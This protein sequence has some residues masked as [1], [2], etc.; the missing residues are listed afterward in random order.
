M[1][2]LVA[3]IAFNE[4]KN[5][6]A[7]LADLSANRREYDVVLVD[8]GSDDSTAA[9]GRAAGIPVL[10][11]CI[12][13]G[14]PAGTVTSY[15]AYAYQ[16]GYDVLCQFDG[17][18]QHIAAELPKIIDPVRRGEADYVIGSRFLEGEGFQSTFARRLGI[19]L[20][21]ALDSLIIGQR[22]S[23]VTSGFRAYGRRVI[24]FFACV[25]RFELHDTNQLLLFSHFSGARI[26]EVPARMR[27]RLH[28]ESEFDLVAS[29]TYP[30]MGAVNILGVLLQRQRIQ[31]RRQ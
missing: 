6:P 24:E 9:L 26:L 8:N 2:T 20:F 31:N 18:G 23:D 22:V 13:S 19:R 21:S 3:I 1:K 7:V 15:F 28:G 30:L 4:A 11:H 12:N 25:Y 16:N 14:G 17:D 29:F 5:L 27:E 10:S